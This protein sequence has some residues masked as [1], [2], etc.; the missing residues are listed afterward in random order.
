MFGEV[1]HML[2]AAD[3]AN[4]HMEIS[5]GAPGGSFGNAGRSPFGGNLLHAPNEVAGVRASVL[6]DVLEHRGAGRVV[7][8]RPH[9]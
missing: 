7:A 8:A 1:R 9:P 3:L 6:Y 2:E 4:C 5:I